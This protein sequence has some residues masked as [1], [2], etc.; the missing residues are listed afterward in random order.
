MQHAI[1]MLDVARGSEDVYRL[2]LSDTSFWKSSK[3]PECPALAQ[4]ILIQQDLKNI[5]N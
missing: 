2:T 3:A 4:S 5:K 1:N